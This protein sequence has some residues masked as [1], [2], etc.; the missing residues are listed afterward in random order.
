[1]S[2]FGARRLRLELDRKFTA[3]NERLHARKSNS[4]EGSKGF[5][6][7]FGSFLEG[8]MPCFKIETPLWKFEGCE[9]KSAVN[10][11]T[12]LDETRRISDVYLELEYRST[13]SPSGPLFRTLSQ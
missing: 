1:M 13:F 6:E 8:I 2:P 11:Q 4:D 10:V 7:G 9:S 12:K 5:H 3:V